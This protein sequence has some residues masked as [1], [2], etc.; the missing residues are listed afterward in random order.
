MRNVRVVNA[1]PAK[2]NLP[3]HAGGSDRVCEQMLMSEVRNGPCFVLKYSDLCFHKHGGNILA[4]TRLKVMQNIWSG[5]KTAHSIPWM[6]QLCNAA[7]LLRFQNCNKKKKT[8]GI[9]SVR[10]EAGSDCCKLLK[11][12]EKKKMQLR[13][14]AAWRL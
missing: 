13:N 10:T 9:L 2:P 7:A 14:F 5:S 6:K 12:A 1:S 11:E 4:R 8:S 3:S